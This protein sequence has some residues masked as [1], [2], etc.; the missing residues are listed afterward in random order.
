MASPLRPPVP[1]GIALPTNIT[2]RDYT[3]QESIVWLVD[4]ETNKAPDGTLT[5]RVTPH[6]G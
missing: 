3:P 6:G 5:I 2:P 4:V 1:N